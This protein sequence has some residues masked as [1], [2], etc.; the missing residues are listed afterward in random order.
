MGHLRFLALVIFASAFASAQSLPLGI[1]DSREPSRAVVGSYCRMD[2]QGYRLAK[3]SWP[4][5]KALTTWKENPDWQGF[6][7]ISQYDLLQADE[8]TRAAVV[9]VRYNILGRFE[10]GLGYV[11]DRANEQVTFFLK[12]E[13]DAWKIT[14][15]D[16]EIN[17]HISKASAVAWL[18]SSIGTEKDVGNKIILQKA[19]KDLGGSP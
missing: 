8:G 9:S 10:V 17:P 7:I 14:S 15:Q 3:T 5:M 2:Y 11:P 16:P 19:L 4:K 6:T 12:D 13:D 18:K 1:R